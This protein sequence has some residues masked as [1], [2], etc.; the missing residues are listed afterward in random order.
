MAVETVKMSSK[1]QIVI[2]QEIREEL[3]AGDGTV[4]AVLGSRDTVVLKK[5]KTPSKED[6]IKE[7]EV[8]ARQGKRRLQAKGIRE[9]D[10]P[11]IVE[12]SQRR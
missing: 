9:S 3:H 12:K 11:E 10:I 7:L 5:I 1:G 4:F 6:L 8:I 2:P